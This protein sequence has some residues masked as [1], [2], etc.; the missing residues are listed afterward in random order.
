M[1]DQ[2]PPEDTDA[3]NEPSQNGSSGELSSGDESAPKPT[4]KNVSSAAI[5]QGKKAVEIVDKA[6][7]VAEGASNA[8]GA[9]KWVS[10]AIVTIIF[11]GG[12]YG[13]YKVVSAPAKAVGH[14]AESVTE[15]VKSGAVK[16]KDSSADVAKRLFIP[17]TQTAQFN[18]RSEAAFLAVSNMA[19]SE[20]AGVKDRL[21]RAKNFNGNAGRVCSFNLDFGNG[22]LPVTKKRSMIMSQNSA[23]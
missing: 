13:L 19:L 23:P 20:A 22:V 9:I 5:A 21:F 4:V 2:T 3:G 16:I 11:A 14:A 8:F 12:A 15:S 17:V 7:T 18:S 10:I 1:A 6:S